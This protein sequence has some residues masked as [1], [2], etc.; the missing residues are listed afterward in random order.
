MGAIHGLR[1]VEANKS[2]QKNSEIFLTARRAIVVA[3]TPILPLHFSRSLHVG[4]LRVDLSTVT[5]DRP[6][7]DLSPYPSQSQ[8]LPFHYHAVP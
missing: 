1:L 8:N 3:L 2:Q 5:H 4:L 7:H 6:T